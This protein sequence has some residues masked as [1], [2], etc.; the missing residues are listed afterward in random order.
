[1]RKRTLPSHWSYA[2]QLHSSNTAHVS[3]HS[4]IKNST[5]AWPTCTHNERSEQAN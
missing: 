3:P 5:C 4:C 2:L 1:M